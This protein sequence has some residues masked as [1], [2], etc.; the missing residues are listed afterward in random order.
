[1][2]TA[3]Q[4]RPAGGVNTRQLW[5][6][7]TAL[8][9]VVVAMGASLVYVQ[10]RPVDGHTAAALEPFSTARPE[11]PPPV[12]GATPLAVTTVAPG[13]TVLTP[14]PAAAAGVPDKPTHALKPKPSAASVPKA[15]AVAPPPPHSAT[16]A[17][18]ATPV[19]AA[20]VI[21]T[22]PNDP[23]VL[24][25]AGPVPSRPLPAAPRAICARCGHVESV[26]TIAR[27]GDAKGVGAVA[28]GV[29]GAV[30]GNQIGKGNGRALATIVGA[31]GGG[32][33]GNAIEK[34][35]STVTVYQVQVRMEDG[36]LRTVEQASAPAV[37][38]AVIV[39][40]ASM[41]PD[42]GRQSPGNGAAALAPAAPRAKVYS[43]DGH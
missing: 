39:E 17:V 36:S 19:P 41:R 4:D 25:N 35:V 9:I 40:G 6:A 37:G 38:S 31:V 42:D 18:N 1:M 13:E 24:A 22:V 33:A 2:N 28:G 16:E 7:V 43:T 10:T 29:L 15:A 12:A 21:G 20:V 30:I 5:A 11:A 23:M 32:V 3:I 8:G 14:A 34:N 27:K 26:T